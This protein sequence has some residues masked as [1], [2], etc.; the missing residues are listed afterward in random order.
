MS[1]IGTAV[2]TGGD[3]PQ[4]GAP[5]PRPR[6]VA[7]EIGWGLASTALLALWIAYQWGW[8][9]ALAGVFGIL[10]HEVGHLL[11]I[12]AL[13][14]G[15]GRIHVIPFFGGAATMKR[16]PRTEYQ[17]VLIALAGPVAGLAAAL[18]FLAAAGL[19]HDRRWAGGAFFIAILNL[20]NLAPAPP[21]DGSKALGPALAWVHPW[22]ERAALVAIGGAAA[23][24][25]FNR[26]SF[27]FG[28]FVAIASLGALR[29]RMQ[30]PAA[31]RLTGGEWLAAIG[32][33]VA[34]LALCLLVLQFSVGGGGTSG[35]LD[36][37]R[38]AGLQ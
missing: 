12:N 9:W 22:L 33:W 34:A 23:L 4:P 3:G 25:A 24:W 18:P 20:V 38:Q 5:A 21:L 11:V 26:G 8:I 1:E 31:A 32:L 15:P 17:G 35:V 30:R 36:A 13:G 10:V 19:T 14:C 28:A 29:G 7:S 16:P 27:L 37:V 2:P 6:S